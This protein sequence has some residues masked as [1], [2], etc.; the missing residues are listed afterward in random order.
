L[1]DAFGEREKSQA[2]E[3]G[4]ETCLPAG[5]FDVKIA[6]KLAILARSM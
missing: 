2:G 6:V 1:A 5:F 3:A 4:F